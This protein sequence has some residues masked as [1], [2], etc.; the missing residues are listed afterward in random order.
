VRAARDSR[1]E[2]KSPAITMAGLF[3]SPRGYLKILCGF[4]EGE[5]VARGLPRCV[6]EGL[7]GPAAG[8]PLVAICSSRLHRRLP[9]IILSNRVTSA[10]FRSSLESRA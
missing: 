7:A 5:D 3:N 4:D 6:F 1:L 10:R 8:L 9:L 2:F